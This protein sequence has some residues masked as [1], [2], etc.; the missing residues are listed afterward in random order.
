LWLAGACDIAIA[1][2]A[3]YLSRIADSRAGADTAPAEQQPKRS[4][5]RQQ[6]GGIALP[7]A[8]ASVGC[9]FFLMEIV[10]YRMLAPILGGTVYTFGLILAAALVGIGAG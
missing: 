10:W 8:A 5:L 9:A 7:V 3:W 4:E 6:G 2:V 1:A